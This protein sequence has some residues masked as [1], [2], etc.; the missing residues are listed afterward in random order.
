MQRVPSVKSGP[1]RPKKRKST[2]LWPAIS[3]W[4]PPTAKSGAE[5]RSTNYYGELQMKQ[6]L[7]KKESEHFQAFCEQLNAVKPADPSA[8]VAVYHAARAELLAAF[9]DS[10]PDSDPVSEHTMDAL[11]STMYHHLT[12]LHSVLQKSSEVVNICVAHEAQNDDVDSPGVKENNSESVSPFDALLQLCSTSYA[13]LH[14]TQQKKVD[15]LMRVLFDSGADRTIV[16][17]P[18]LPM[19]ISPSEGKKRKVT[20]VTATSTLSDEV[21]LTD[22][23]LPE[24]SRN[25]LPIRAIIMDNAE[26]SYD[27]ILG[28]D[29][30]QALCI[31]ICNSSKSVVWN[32]VS[33]PFKSPFYFNKQTSLDVMFET[34][35]VEDDDHLGYK[36]KSSASPFMNSV[37]PKTLPNNKST[38]IQWQDLASVLGQFP[39]LSSGKLGCFPGKPVH[40]ELVPNAVPF[41]CRPYNVPRHHEAVFQAKLKRLCEIKILEPCGP[42]EW[43]S[44][45]FIIPNKNGRVRRITDSVRFI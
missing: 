45:T 30:L 10:I 27:L 11:L 14:T 37:T 41:T 5:T 32:G 20:G 21:S 38:P 43:L 40:L 12:P 15:V 31:D 35:R 26:P 42:S 39:K 3:T 23:V 22:V 1:I 17:R 8:M 13:I 16:S 25:T 34:L 29:L 24:F 33:I 9:E 28:M 19:G 6:A 7:N 36:S 4:M 44:P 18:A 2:P